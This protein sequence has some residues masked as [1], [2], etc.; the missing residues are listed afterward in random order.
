MSHG[1]ALQA[2]GKIIIV[3]VFSEV[4]GQ[5][6]HSTLARLN[7]DGSLDTSFNELDA[8]YAI[9]EMA[10]QADDKIVVAGNFNLLDA[11]THHGIGRLNS[12]GTR[13]YSLHD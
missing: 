13:G 8:D 10:I 5:P 2:D 7:I 9:Y 6:W 1:I 12:D 4:D 3:G 11:E